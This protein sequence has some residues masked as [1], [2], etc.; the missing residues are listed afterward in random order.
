MVAVHALRFTVHAVYTFLLPRRVHVAFWLRS[1]YTARCLFCHVW[2]TGSPP[3]RCSSMPPLPLRLLLPHLHIPRSHGCRLPATYT[4]L[5]RSHVAVLPIFATPLSADSHHAVSSV[6]SFG[7]VYHCGSRSA[8][9]TVCGCGSRFCI[10]HT[11]APRRT[12]HIRL[13]CWFTAARCYVTVLP[14]TR[15]CHTTHAFSHVRHGWFTFGFLW[16]RL[17]YVWITAAVYTLGSYSYTGYL[18]VVRRFLCH[19]VLLHALP[20][21]TGSRLPR[22]RHGCARLPG[23]GC[24]YA[25]YIY[26]TRSCYTAACGSFCTTPFLHTHAVLPQFCRACSAG[27]RAL[28]LPFCGSAAHVWLHRFVTLRR[29]FLR[30][31]RFGYIYAFYL[32]F[33]PTTILFT[34]AYRFTAYCLHVRTLPFGCGS[35]RSAHLVWFTRYMVARIPRSCGYA[36]V[37]L[38]L[39]SRLVLYLPVPGYVAGWFA[40]HLPVTFCVARLPFVRITGGFTALIRTPYYGLHTCH[41]YPYLASAFWLLVTCTAFA[42]PRGY[43]YLHGYRFR[44]VLVLR[45]HCWLPVTRRT[46]VCTGVTTTRY[47]CRGSVYATLPVLLHAHAHAHRFTAGLRFYHHALPT[48]GCTLLGSTT[49]RACRCHVRPRLLVYLPPPA[50]R[51]FVCCGC[52]RFTPHRTGSATFSSP[53]LVHHT[54]LLFTG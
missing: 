13:R 52:T 39:R 26:T 18:P 10:T 2:F 50:V 44:F 8:Y 30:F 22:I 49:P 41:C 34:F 29:T 36:H 53:V 33:Y 3:Y 14:V 5:P 46:R 54:V 27:L 7:Y 48:Y 31:L 32:L 20:F 16:L 40:Q 51:T 37:R 19:T 42:L 28:P 35:L 12:P 4:Y 15:Y 38:R 45:V 1:H 17:G 6:G 21:A 43:G 23:S 9:R 47:G 24:L 11:V 25:G